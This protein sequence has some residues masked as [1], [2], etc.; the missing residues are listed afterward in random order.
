MNL[1]KKVL[2]AAPMVVA[3][4][5]ILTFVMTYQN[6]GF[7]NRFVEQ[8]LTSTLLSATT[9]API[10]FAMVMVI[11]KVAESLMPNTAKIIKIL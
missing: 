3:L 1:I 8:W 2:V 11:S 6:I 9:I 4:V 10:G 5:G 7:T